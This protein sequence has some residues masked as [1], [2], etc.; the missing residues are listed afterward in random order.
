MAKPK[1]QHWVP[2]F[3]LKS[4][5]T[6]D[7][8]DA[9][10]P[11]VWV[12]G[13]NSGDPALTNVRNIAAER[14]LYS[15]KRTGGSRDWTMEDRLANLEAL[16]APIWPEVA[17]GFMDL[18]GS[19]S[20]RKA[21][22][23]FVSTLHFRH[24]LS[25]QRVAQTHSKLIGLFEDFPK[26][27]HGN[28]KVLLL[29]RDGSPKV[30]DNSNYQQWSNAGP[31]DLHQMFVD[32]ISDHSGEFAQMLLEKRWSVVFTDDPV[33]ITTDTPVSIV[34]GHRTPFGITTPG[35]VLSFPLSPTRILMMDDRHDQ[36]KGQYYPLGPYGPGPAN[37]MAWH[38]CHRFMISPRPTD[39]VCAEMLEW[40]DS[41][42]GEQED[43]QAV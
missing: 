18:N 4:F 24:P 14:Y 10:E 40:A 12:L 25:R 13:K 29:D 6:S 9:A 43:T 30:I 20:L 1:N 39:Y 34:N 38:C 5:A 8:R 11:K 15:P 17:S 42:Q 23:L 22:A 28:P 2:R 36:P 3:Y 41:S 16:V 21:I 27:E 26:D 33:F 31:D 7:T 19:T 35:T 32:S 37:L